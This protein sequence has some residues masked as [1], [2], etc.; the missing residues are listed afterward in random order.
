MGRCCVLCITLLVLCGACNERLTPDIAAPEQ[1]VTAE[2][3]LS[4]LRLAVAPLSAVLNADGYGEQNPQA[5]GYLTDAAKEQT[6]TAVREA[7]QKYRKTENGRRALTLL[8]HELV[9]MIQQA[10]DDDRWRLVLGAVEA[11]ELINPESSSRMERLKE[12]ARVHFNR[13]RVKVLGYFDDLEKNDV[14]VF[15]EVTLRETGEVEIVQV[16]EGD[17]F[18]GLK[19]LGIIGRKKGVRLEYEKVAGDVFKV[20]GP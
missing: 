4:E 8:E 3:I 11:Y 12:R 5:P 9:T 14:Y 17:E 16:R 20:Y 19:L 15:L 7:V 6:L 1:P 13:P 2:A 18:L 10:R